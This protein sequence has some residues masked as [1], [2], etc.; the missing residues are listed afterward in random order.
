MIVLKKIYYTTMLTNLQL[1][2][3]ICF[4]RTPVERTYFFFFLKKKKKLLFD[5]ASTYVDIL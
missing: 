3:S 2:Q 4:F 5:N 1:S